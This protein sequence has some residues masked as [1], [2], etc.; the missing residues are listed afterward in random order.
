VRIYSFWALNA[1]LNAHEMIAQLGELLAAGFDGVVMQPRFY[2]PPPA[3]L[4]PEWFSVLNTVISAY[5]GAA[6]YLQDENGWPAPSVDGRLLADEPALAQSWVSAYARHEIPALATVVGEDGDCVFV[7]EWGRY[8]DTLNPRTAARFWALTYHP[9]CEALAD[10]PAF[11]GFFCDEP[12]FGPLDDG[13]ITPVNATW[14]AIPWTD[15]LAAEYA[16]RYGDDLLPRLRELFF[17]HPGSAGTRRHFYE[18]CA[19]LFR[20]RFVTPLVEGCRA[21]G[22][23]WEGHFK[24]EEHP[25]FQLW[26]SGPC[27]WLYRAMG[28]VGAD[29]LERIPGERYFLREAATA[30]RQHG[31]PA[32]VECTGG[33][34]WGMAPSHYWSYGHWLA[35]HGIDQLVLHQAQYQFTPL[36][37]HDWPPSVPLHQPYREAWPTLLAGWRESGVDVRQ[38]HHPVLVIVPYRGL[39]ERLRPLERPLLDVHAAVDYA[40]SPGGQVNRSILQRLHTLDSELLGYDVVNERDF[41]ADAA[42]DNGLC[43]GTCRY[44]ALL[45]LPGCVLNAQAEATIQQAADAGVL[46]FDERDAPVPD[47]IGRMRQQLTLPITAATPFPAAVGGEVFTEGA[48]SRLMLVNTDPF[49]TATVHIRCAGTP[50]PLAISL[51][52]GEVKRGDPRKLAREHT[53]H[54]VQCRWQATRQAPNLLPLDHADAVGATRRTCLFSFN[55]VRTLEPGLQLLSL[56]PVE[57]IVL[58]SLPIGAL[59]EAACVAGLYACALPVPISTG[60]HRVMIRFAQPW[61]DPTPPRIWLAGEFAVL[62]PQPWQPGPHGTQKNAGP[63]TLSPLSTE[64]WKGSELVAEGYPF[65]TGS[66]RYEARFTASEAFYAL[67]LAARGAAARITVDDCDLGWCW[68]PRWTVTASTPFASGEHRIVVELTTTAFNLLGPHRHRDGDP[69]LVVTSHFT[70][71][72]DFAQ[73]DDDTPILVPDYHVLSAGLDPSLTLYG[74]EANHVY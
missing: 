66:V 8:A 52:P 44:Q 27:T 20:E 43:V 35:M 13:S 24:G 48:Q 25:Y 64:A 29:M 73:S 3:Y 37:V 54:T 12:Q 59:P 53:G 9:T 34:G 55:A 22:L 68:G 38:A 23:A 74:I 5:P 71:V 60:G 2:Q 65:Y 32:L 40:K 36:A 26:F 45:I 63:F 57:G 69:T 46:L 7:R 14:G 16:A 30:I 6:I 21:R 41:E 17:D 11:H 70:G 39:M 51:L 1:P 50:D 4:S 61:D 19:D 15:D 58:D 49:A 31:L 62:T 10:L 18:L 67:G 33:G 42:C 47:L 28:R 72:R 56:L